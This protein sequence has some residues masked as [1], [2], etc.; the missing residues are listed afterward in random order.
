MELARAGK[1]GHEVSRKALGRE[2][3]RHLA[4]LQLCGEAAVVLNNA[5]TDTKH[6]SVTCHAFIFQ[7]ALHSAK[8]GNSFAN[9]NTLGCLWFPSSKNTY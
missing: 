9:L 5:H 1:L 2:A 6:N 4:S 7:R 3:W 8:Q